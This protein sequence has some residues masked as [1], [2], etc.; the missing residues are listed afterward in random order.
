MGLGPVAEAIAADAQVTLDTLAPATAPVETAPS[1]AEE[2]RE[3]PSPRFPVWAI[4]VL[5]LFG[6]GMTGALI[7]LILAGIRSA[8][9]SPRRRH[10]DDDSSFFTSDNSSS[11]DSSSS[12]SSSSGDSFSGGDGGDSGGGGAS[13]SW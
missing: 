13:G 1:T 10:Q 6:L 8:Q 12:V 9:S 5:V 4:V 7:A 11:S 3:K 2:A